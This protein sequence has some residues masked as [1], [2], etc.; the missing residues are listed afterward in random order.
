MIQYYVSHL[1]RRTIGRPKK[2]WRQQ[3]S[4]DGTDQIVQSLMFMM[5]MMMNRD[6]KCL[7]RRTD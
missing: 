2:R 6:G 5:M 1:G 4:G 7:Q 3:L